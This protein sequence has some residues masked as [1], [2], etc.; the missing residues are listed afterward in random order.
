VAS[1]EKGTHQ[2]ATWVT[3]ARDRTIELVVDLTDE[4]M[5]GP[6]L[7]IVNPL[8]WEIGHVAWFQERWVLRRS[9]ARPMPTSTGA[10][11]A[12]SMSARS[13]RATAPGAAGR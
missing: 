11:G 4:Q 6:R 10:P 7:Q 8:W 13:R 3:D 1:K 5:L 2:L 12:V 9:G